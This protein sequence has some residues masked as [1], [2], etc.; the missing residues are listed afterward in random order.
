MAVNAE[1]QKYGIAHTEK[2]VTVDASP[3]TLTEMA[4]ARGE[5]K[6][7]STGCL[8]VLTGDYTGRSPNDR[9]IVDTPDVHDR[10]A[11]G[12]T[13]VPI[14]IENYEKIRSEAV[15]YLSERRV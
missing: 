1:L 6:L 10:I 9:F 4:L 7:T 3:A 12:K 15:A 2:K 13:N 14:S 8:A 11:W 5:G